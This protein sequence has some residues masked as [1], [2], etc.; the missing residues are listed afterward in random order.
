MRR[1]KAIFSA[2]RIL[3][4]DPHK[5]I[6]AAWDKVYSQID[7]DLVLSA[8]LHL[9]SQVIFGVCDEAEAYMKKQGEQVDKG[10]A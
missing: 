2:I 3:G 5:D 4:R 8:D 7:R 9:V 6:L 10:A 1:I